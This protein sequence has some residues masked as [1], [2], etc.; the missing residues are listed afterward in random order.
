MDLFFLQKEKIS[1]EL[2]QLISEIMNIPKD[3]YVIL[4]NEYPLVSMAQGGLLISKK[5]KNH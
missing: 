2:M 4:F 3:A 1:K 5:L